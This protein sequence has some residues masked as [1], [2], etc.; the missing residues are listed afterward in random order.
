M[1]RQVSSSPSSFTP[2]VFQHPHRDDPDIEEQFVKI[3]ENFVSGKY[4]SPNLLLQGSPECGAG[5]GNFSLSAVSPPGIPRQHHEAPLFFNK[6]LSAT[7]LLLPD[8][9]SHKPQVKNNDRLLFTAGGTRQN[10]FQTLPIKEDPVYVT[11]VTTAIALIESQ[12]D[13]CAALSRLLQ[14]RVINW[15]NIDDVIPGAQYNLRLLD[16]AIK[17]NNIGAVILLIKYG[18]EIDGDKAMGKAQERKSFGFMSPLYRAILLGQK[19]IALLLLNGITV[20][21]YGAVTVKKANPYHKSGAFNENCLRLA[22][23]LGAAEIVAAIHTWSR[24]RE[25][26]AAESGPISNPHPAGGNL[27]QGPGRTARLNPGFD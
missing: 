17:E 8:N 15:T 12:Q 7:I 1:V 2:P 11:A 10:E 25:E 22:S 23:R 18:A 26:E 14:E 13:T 6:S 20:N 9:F 24:E 27:S 16:L 3:E 5:P 4:K 19:K 21:Y